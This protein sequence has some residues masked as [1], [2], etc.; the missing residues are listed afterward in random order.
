MRACT[1][2]T[3]GARAAAT[4]SGSSASALKKRRAAGAAVAQQQVCQHHPG[5]Q[6]VHADAGHACAQHSA[7]HADGAL[8]I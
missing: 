5:R 8:M 2:R 4:V 1:A 6:V 7:R 3:R